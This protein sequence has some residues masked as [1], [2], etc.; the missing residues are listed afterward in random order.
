M[1]W[2]HTGFVVLLAA[3]FFMFIAHTFISICVGM[4]S[5]IRV[6]DYFDYD[7]GGKFYVS[8]SH[9]RM[10]IYWRNGLRYILGYERPYLPLMPRILIISS[11]IGVIS[12]IFCLSLGALRGM[13]LI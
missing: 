10:M 1:A 12:T 11:G 8:D 7:G 6:N 3:A 9:K 4:F 2:L 13:E 5:S